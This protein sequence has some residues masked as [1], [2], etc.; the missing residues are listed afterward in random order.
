MRTALLATLA[1]IALPGGL[2]RGFDVTACGQTAPE[3]DVG[4]LQ[5]DLSGFS[6]ACVTLEDRASLQLN[7]HTI[8]GGT[9]AVHCVENC[10]VTGPGALS[11]NSIGRSTTSASIR[12]SSTRTRP[13]SGRTTAGSP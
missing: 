8:T 3:R 2:S 6:G 9:I 12:C 5:V 4:V 11:Q 7:G 1:S 13:P 10:S